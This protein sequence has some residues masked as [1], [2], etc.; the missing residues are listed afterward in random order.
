M[1]KNP[2]VSII[3]ATYNWPHALQLCL[4]SLARQTNLDFEVVIADDGSAYETKRMID[5][6]EV[7]A[8]FPIRHEWQEDNGFRKAKI[9][10]KAINRAQNAY[11]IFLDGDCIVQPD[12]VFQHLKLSQGGAMVT[13]SRILLAKKITELLCQGLVSPQSFFNS[14]ALMLRLAGQMN[15]C[16]PLLIKLPNHSGRLYSEFTWRR[17]KGCNMAA[18]RADAIQ[19]GGFDESLEG[20]GHEDADFVFRL[21][22]AGIVRK[23]GS[24]S[25]EVF[26]LWH[27]T[28][29]KESAT[30]NAEIV[31][32][33]IM[34]EKNR[35]VLSH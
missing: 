16:L 8:P 15:K 35:H 25:T 30:K 27:K 28:A 20:W 3:L 10:N 33:K 23:S 2:S 17:I 29:S 34:A 24:W 7:N 11:L 19:I 6:F 22:L 12:F 5:E 21:H 32:A 26:H 14:K 9:L 13:G 1:T 18:W 4:Q 31:R